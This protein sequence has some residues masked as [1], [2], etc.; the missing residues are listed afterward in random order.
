MPWPWILLGLL[1]LRGVV[2]STAADLGQLR[3]KFK[4]IFRHDG[5]LGDIADF[6]FHA[7]IVLSGA[8]AQDVMNVFGQTQQG[9]RSDGR[10]SS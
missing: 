9:Q 7:V 5:D 1:P 10:G 8:N 3:A 6:R 2:F 4:P